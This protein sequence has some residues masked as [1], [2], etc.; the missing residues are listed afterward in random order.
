MRV[1]PDANILIYAADVRAGAKHAAALSLAARMVGR[2]CILVLQ[3][4]AEFF[5]ATT[6]KGLLTAT[7]AAAAVDRWKAAFEVFAVD[8]AGLSRAIDAVQRHQM[9]FWDAM[10]WSV[11][12]SASCDLLLTEDMHDGQRVGRVTFVNPFNPANRAL[13]DRALPI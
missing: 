4:L 10:L 8:E 13:I 6:R 7:A 5:N 11:A 12:D 3:T 9:S 2:D 1:A